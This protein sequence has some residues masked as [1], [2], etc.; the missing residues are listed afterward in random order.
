VK[1]AKREMKENENCNNRR[2]M[3][4]YEMSRKKKREGE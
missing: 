2:I 1:V 4:D 3:N